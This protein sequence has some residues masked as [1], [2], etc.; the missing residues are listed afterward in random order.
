[1]DTFFLILSL[2]YATLNEGLETYLGP[3]FF[4]YMLHS[5]GWILEVFLLKKK[6]NS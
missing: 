5:F 2:S 1:M 3:G 4:K 6:L